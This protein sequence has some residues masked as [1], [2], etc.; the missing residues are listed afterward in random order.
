MFTP[1][2]KKWNVLEDVRMRHGKIILMA[3][4]MAALAQVGC[5]PAE[6]T[7]TTTANTN[8]AK[9]E[10]TPDKTAIT[11][12][13]TRIENDWP[14]ILKEKD[15][16]TVRRI[17]ADDIVLVYPD[18]SAGGKDQD[19][20]DIEAGNLTYESWDISDLAVNVIDADVAVASLRITVKGGKYKTP[21]GKSEDI[22][23]QYRSIDTFARR[24]GQWQIVASAV[25]PVRSPVAA[26]S[27]AGAASPS[28]A[29]KA[30]PGE[31]PSPAP[32]ASPRR[33]PVP[34]VPAT[35]P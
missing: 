9:P 20:K 3:A 16:A 30:S 34:P 23:G 17:E 13:I 32:K 18:G 7:N 25:T 28:P 11:A 6:N 22:S 24:N 10:A 31:K 15:V 4:V 21:E 5:A 29:M 35:T 1:F 8:M 19:T 2:G 33:K 27:P 26:A 14:R 12:E